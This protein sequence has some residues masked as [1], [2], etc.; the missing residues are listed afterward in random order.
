MP[1]ATHTATYRPPHELDVVMTLAPLRRGRGDPTMRFAADGVWRATRTPEGAATVHLR[2]DGRDIAVR[3]WG[4]G[5]EWAA[6]A[7]PDLL[8]GRDDPRSFAPSQPLVRRLHRALP[9]LRITRSGSVLEALV[10]SILEQKVV[11]IEA[12]RAYRALVRVHGERAPGPVDLMLSPAPATLAALPYAAMHRFGVERRRA[13]TIRRAAAAADRLERAVDRPLDEARRLLESVPGVGSWTAAEVA[14]VALGDADAVSVG[15]YH[16]PN[17][18]AWVL[19]GERRAD[20]ARM[21]ELLEP[22]RGHRGRV[23]R[24]IGA[25][26]LGPPRRGPRMATPWWRPRSG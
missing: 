20:D 4:P 21:L 8:G 1:T 13:E 23:I 6:A 26:G 15:D 22:Y 11:G 9:G 24:L 2:R 16:L 18:V 5:A 7:V 14:I 12:R 25:A 3:A 19:A 10:P 17:H